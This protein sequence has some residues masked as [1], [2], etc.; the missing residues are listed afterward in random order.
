[1]KKSSCQL[2]FALFLTVFLSL[3][4]TPAVLATETKSEDPAGIETV[5][6][7]NEFSDWL[8]LHE[9]P[10]GTVVLAGVL[11]LEDFSFVHPWNK[12][13]IVIDTADYY[14]EA[15][16]YVELYAANNITIQGKGGETGVLRAGKGSR[17]AVQGISLAAA[18][19]LAAVQEEGAGFLFENASAI[20][21]VRYAATPFVWEWEDPLFLVG[22]NN[23]FNGSSLP[24]TL[25]GKVNTQGTLTS[26]AMPIPVVWNLS[27]T[28][29]S[30]RLRQRFALPGSF[31]NMTTWKNPEYTVVYDDYPLTFRDVNVRR[32]EGTYGEFY[33]IH[34]SFSVSD[35]QLPITVV[36]EYSKDGKTWDYLA[37]TTENT[38]NPGFTMTLFIPEE[39]QEEYSKIYIR[40]SANL[41]G[42]L[43]YSN[44]I[45]FDSKQLKPY[46]LPDGNR[47]G[48]TD[49]VSPPATPQPLPTPDMPMK[50]EAPDE[51]PGDEEK[52]QAAMTPRPSRIPDLQPTPKPQATVMPQPTPDEENPVFV[53]NSPASTSAAPPLNETQPESSKLGILPFAAG[54]AALILCFALAALYLKRKK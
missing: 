39:Q 36:Q 41:E 47:G 22:K 35:D 38:V 26:E 51:H 43:Y 44:V 33:R 11:T 54:T 31:T 42:I 15:K 18:S 40:Q 52:P 28:E 20:G 6:S 5:C 9:D 21:E 10:G 45:G 50:P 14:L 16:G 32:M 46:G 24:E 53:Q 37:E 13:E 3:W 27:G 17:L 2:V 1:M 8:S 49:L 7:Q 48:G 12:P 4:L 29:E 19:G 34:G 25:E 30:Q 23:D